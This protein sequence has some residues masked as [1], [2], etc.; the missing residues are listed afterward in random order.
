VTFTALISIIE[1]VKFRGTTVT[2]SAGSTG[3]P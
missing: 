3:N 1:N 2:G